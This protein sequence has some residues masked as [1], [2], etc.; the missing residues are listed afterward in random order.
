MTV[1]INIG[2]QAS[3][4]YPEEGRM[5]AEQILAA[6]PEEFTWA[7]VIRPSTTEPTLVVR[8]KDSWAPAL[9]GD[10]RVA[11][12][13]GRLYWLCV[14]CQQDAIAFTIDGVGY[15]VGPAAHLWGEFSPEFFLTE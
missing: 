10:A 5:T 4:R 2:L 6:L 15:L 13:T 1:I 8:L 12:W 9:K 3:T 7:G 11:W 14:K